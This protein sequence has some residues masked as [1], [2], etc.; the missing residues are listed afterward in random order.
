MIMSGIGSRNTLVSKLNELSDLGLL[1][2]ENQYDLKTNSKMANKYT[3]V[4]V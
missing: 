2:V 1:R 3:L 4:S